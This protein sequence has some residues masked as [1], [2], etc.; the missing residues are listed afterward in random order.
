MTPKIHFISGL[1]RSGST[2]LGVLLRQNP[3]FH[4]SMTSP[5]GSLVNRMLEHRLSNP[6]ITSPPTPPLVGEGS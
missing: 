4:A 3:Q 1:P 5:V 6:G 2:L